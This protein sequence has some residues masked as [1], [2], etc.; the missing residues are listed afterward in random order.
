MFGKDLKRPDGLTP[1]CKHCRNV[2][3]KRR[4]RGSVNY[5]N[6]LRKRMVKMATPQWVN[7]EEI[8]AIY[9]K[10]AQISRES[11]I[12]YHVDHIYPIKNKLLCGL[13][14]PWNLQIIPA[15]KNCSKKNKINFEQL[16]ESSPMF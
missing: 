14:V 8:K 16:H 7:C 3:Y 1:Q 2:E 4:N 15:T 10:A 13:N 12:S 9:N 6:A 11:G 5:H